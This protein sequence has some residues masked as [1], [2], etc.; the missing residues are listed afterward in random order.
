MEAIRAIEFSEVKMRGAVARRR[1]AHFGWLYGYETWR[2]EPGPPIPGFLLP[3]RGRVG[4]LAGVSADEL[5]EV[6]LTEYTPGAGIG[7]HRDA[8]MFGVVAGVSLLGACR[9]RFERGQG[10]GARDPRDH[11]GPALGLSADGR[12]P[13][14]LAPQHPAD[15]AAALLGDLPD[16]ALKRRHRFAQDSDVGPDLPVH[17]RGKNPSRARRGACHGNCLLLN[18]STVSRP[19]R[20]WR[21]V[22]PSLSPCGPPAASSTRSPKIRLE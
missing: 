22:L 14:E 1:T 10:R 21:T 7:W 6:L 5:V 4:E 8:P 18:F 19:R 11:A 17:S 12:G 9:F 20:S 3:L 13:P 16:P 15:E 2:I